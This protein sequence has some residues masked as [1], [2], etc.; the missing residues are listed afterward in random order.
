[1]YYDKFEVYLICYMYIVI[2]NH[3]NLDK[4][5]KSLVKLAS[6]LISGFVIIMGRGK[7]NYVHSPMQGTFKLQTLSKQHNVLAMPNSSA[8]AN[9][10]W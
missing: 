5:L 8:I 3:S 9:L 10:D 7:L 4:L 1:M 2:A 6:N